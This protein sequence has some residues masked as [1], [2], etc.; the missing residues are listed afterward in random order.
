MLQHTRARVSVESLKSATVASVRAQLALL[1]V[2]VAVVLLIATT[3]VVN[4]F[5]LRTERASQEIAIALSL[6]ATRVALAQRFVIEGIV[7][8]LASAIVALPAAALAVST[9]FGFTDREIPRLHEVSFGAQ[10][11]GLVLACAT[12]LGAAVGFIALTRTSVVGLFD[13]LRTSRSTSSLAW[14]R[15]QSGLVSFQVAIALMLLVAAGLLGRSFWNL[16][17]ATIGFEP[18]NAMMFQASLPWEGY[19]SYADN[20][21][22]HA[23]MIDRLAALPGVTAVGVASRLPLASRGAPNLD[24]QLYADDEKARPPIAAAGN[25][26]SADYLELPFR[27][28]AWRTGGGRERT[29]RDELV[30]DDGRCRP[31]HRASTLRRAVDVIHDRWRGCRRALGTHRGWLCADG[32]FPAAPRR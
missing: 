32:V 17:T 13:R 28:P 30:R 14:R 16:R 11:V 12:L 18:A 7:L 29:S 19:T 24:T 1:G 21:A 25:I 5:L 22:F 31:A 8:G 23:K 20:A 27:R 4:L 3:N 15:A 9:K 10:T 26:A 6:G 2:L